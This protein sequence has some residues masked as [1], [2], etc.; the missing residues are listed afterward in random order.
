MTKI[1][2]CVVVTYNRLELLKENL[3]KI[4]QQTYPIRTIYIID[5][6]STDGTTEYLNKYKNN[7]KY[8]VVTLEKNIGGAGG[9]TKGIELSAIHH[10]EWIWVM[11]DDTMPTEK[12][13]E[14]LIPY[15]EIGK[16]GYVCS[17]VL[18]MDGNPHLMNV[19]RQ[20]EDNSLVDS[21]F[22][23]RK[24]L[25]LN[26]RLTVNASFVSLLINGEIPWKIGLPYP[27]FF[28]WCDDAEYT[29]RITQSGYLGIQTENSIVYHKTKNNYESSIDT[30]DANMSWKLYYGE[31]NASFIRKKRKGNIVFF[32]SQL[33]EL[34]LHRHKIKKRRL[35]KEDEAKLLEASWRGLIDGFSFNPRL[36]FPQ[37]DSK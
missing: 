33:N 31:R 30:L 23:E 36:R 13:L 20:L 28:I 6:H 8:K 1:V 18:W 14:N 11:D 5:N 10:A 9:F 35:P 2:D 3:A 27:E 7:N 26:T 24:D 12:A 19:T 25:A 32:F 4:E 22:H 34:R 29:Y 21:V 16:T 37:K 15:T 17:Q